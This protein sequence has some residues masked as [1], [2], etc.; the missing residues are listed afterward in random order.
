MNFMW[1]V[2]LNTLFGV[3]LDY[4]SGKIMDLWLYIKVRDKSVYRELEARL[5]DI[6]NPDLDFVGEPIWSQALMVMFVTLFAFT[7]WPIGM[8]VGLGSAIKNYKKVYNEWK[9]EES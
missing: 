3:T 4:V 5:D 7:L 2:A 9:K 1:I 6:S 8:I